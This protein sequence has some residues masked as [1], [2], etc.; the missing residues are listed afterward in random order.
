MKRRAVS[1]LQGFTLVELMIVVVIIGILAATAI[2]AFQRQIY[3]A[4]AAEAPG[5]IGQI[6]MAE[7]SYRSEFAQYSGPT[8]FGALYPTASVTAGPVGWTPASAPSE[9]RF[10]GITPDGPVRFR[11]RVSSGYGAAPATQF[12]AGYDDWWYIIQ[13]YGDMDMDGTSYLVEGMSARAQLY[14]SNSAGFE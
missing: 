9:L 10:M 1:S 5:M 7:E 13:A 8:A 12:P 6:R 2:P 14:V 3:R 11:Y 4:R